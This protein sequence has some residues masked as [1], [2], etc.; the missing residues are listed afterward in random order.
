MMNQKENA[1][2][3]KRFCMHC[4][5]CCSS[6][7]CVDMKAFT[8]MFIFLKSLASK[9]KVGMTHVLN[10]GLYSSAAFVSGK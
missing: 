6:V 8:A 5:I 10:I 9:L 2:L 4:A 1:Y 7:S 3:Y